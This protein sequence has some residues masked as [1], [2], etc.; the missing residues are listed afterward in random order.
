MK[1][2]LIMLINKN[3]HNR[4]NFRENIKIFHLTRTIIKLRQI[5]NSLSTIYMLNRSFF[6]YL[7][8]PLDYLLYHFNKKAIEENQLLPSSFRVFPPTSHPHISSTNCLPPLSQ[9]LNP[10]IRLFDFHPLYPSPF[11]SNF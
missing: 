2:L 6:C 5:I 3:T 7:T 8:F 11:V 4:I 9:L 10:Q 1:Y